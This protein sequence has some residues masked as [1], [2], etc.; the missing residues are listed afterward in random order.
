MA[1]RIDR[2]TWSPQPVFGLVGEHG[3][4]ERSALESTLNM[5]VGMVAI[6]HPDD[7][8]AAVRLLGELGVVAWIC[9]ETSATDGE[10]AG[11]VRMA[12]EYA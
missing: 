5:G 12:G 10:D 3:R 1:G 4:V 8:D 11:T 2:S 6:L 9:G 7:A